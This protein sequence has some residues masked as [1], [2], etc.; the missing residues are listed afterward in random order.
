GLD[1]RDPCLNRPYLLVGGCESAIHCRLQAAIQLENRW[2]PR[3]MRT[4]YDDHAIGGVHAIGRREYLHGV[5]ETSI[6]YWQVVR[7]T[8]VVCVGDQRDA[9]CGFEMENVAS[10][11]SD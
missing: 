8:A 2:V 1:R 4:L 10:A 5:A 7:P 11:Y 9:G 6:S 3:E